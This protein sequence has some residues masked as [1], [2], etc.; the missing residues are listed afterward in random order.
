MIDPKVLERLH[1]S[2]DFLLFLEEVAA[3]REATVRSLYGCNNEQLQQKAG[4][5]TAYTD[6][7]DESQLEKLRATWQR[8]E[9]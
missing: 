3:N 6:L 4:I 2:R 5:I 8:I 7:L 9:Q 1:N